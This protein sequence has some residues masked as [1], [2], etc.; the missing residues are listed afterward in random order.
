M[1]LGL[2]LLDP[3]FLPLSPSPPLLPRYECQSVVLRHLTSKTLLRVCGYHQKVCVG[4]HD[5]MKIS[6]ELPNESGMCTAHYVA[7]F[8]KRPK[9]YVLIREYV[10]IR[11][12][13]SATTW[14]CGLY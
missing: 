7:A 4:E 3:Y 2:P 12:L 5:G 9:T 11:Q 6:A 8:K 14:R 1:V 13:Y 10:A